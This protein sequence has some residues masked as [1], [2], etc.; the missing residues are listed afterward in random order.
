MRV[1]DIAKQMVVLMVYDDDDKKRKHSGL[2]N[3]LCFVVVMFDTRLP[4]MLGGWFI[5]QRW[6]K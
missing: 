5:S 1:S 6:F 2:M 4:R 3:D